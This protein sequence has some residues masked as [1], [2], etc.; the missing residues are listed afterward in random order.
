MSDAAHTGSRRA[1]AEYLRQLLLKPGR[2][3]DEWQQHVA[4]PRDGVINQMAVA[5]VIAGRLRSAPGH[6]GDAQVVPYQ[7]RET[8]LGALAGRELSQQTLE[9][10][11]A[12]FAFSGHEAERLRRLH[13]GSDRISVISG[14][15][16][17]P[18]EAERD[19]DR[20]FGPRRHRTL[21]LHDHVY[22]GADGRID[23]ARAIQVIEATAPGVDRIPFLCDTQVL[24]LEVGQG[25][26][27]LTGEVHQI[28]DDVFFTEILLARTLELGETLTLEFWV[29][30]RFPGDGA[31]PAEREFRRAVM[32]QVENLDM[33]VEFH[34][35]RLPLRLWWAHWDGVDGDVLEREAVTLDKQHSAHRYLRSLEKTV[36]GFCW[37]WDG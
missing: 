7:L 8:I 4:R 1:A 27:E 6:P 9:L 25:G 30:Y 5:E 20:A 13:A 3:R 29:T 33:R 35:G 23:R 15:R 36:A 32:R 17:V 18:V 14:R 19:V 12:A 11:I 2:Y 34:P 10:F 24:T 21:S 16:A 37:Q 22:V 31:D 28:G 26:K